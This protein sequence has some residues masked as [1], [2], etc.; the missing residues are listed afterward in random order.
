M[1]VDNICAWCNLAQIRCCIVNLD[2]AEHIAIADQSGVHV[3]TVLYTRPKFRMIFFLGGKFRADFWSQRGGLRWA[4]SKRAAY[5]CEES[6]GVST[7]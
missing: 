1:H 6:T 4:T 3:R 2:A 7:L 5:V